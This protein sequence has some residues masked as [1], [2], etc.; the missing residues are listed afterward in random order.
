MQIRPILADEIE[1]ARLLLAANAWGPRVADVE[2]FRELVSRSQVAL[3]AVQGNQV[4]G[5][6]R[7]LTDGIFNGSCRHA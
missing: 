7:A 4:I 5:F 1:A 6:L 3:V 2:V